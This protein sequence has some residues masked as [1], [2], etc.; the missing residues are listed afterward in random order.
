[1]HSKISLDLDYFENIVLY[2]I[3][4]DSS[5]LNSIIDKLDEKYIHNKDNK[6]VYE[7]KFKNDVTSLLEASG[8]QHF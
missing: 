8:K 1:M 4:T 2:K 5:Y 3:L 6:I 7:G